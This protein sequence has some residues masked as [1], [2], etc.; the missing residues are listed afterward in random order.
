MLSYCSVVCII[1]II[2]IIII[3]ENYP[4]GWVEGENNLEG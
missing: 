4:L 3:W 1:I 2:I